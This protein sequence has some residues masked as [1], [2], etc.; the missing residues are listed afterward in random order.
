LNKFINIYSARIISY[1]IEYRTVE[2]R[3]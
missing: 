1:I 2:W 3:S